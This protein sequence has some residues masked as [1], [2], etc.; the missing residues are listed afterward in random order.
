[1]PVH[2]DET[3]LI[4]SITQRLITLFNALKRYE[5]LLNV[6]KRH[7]TLYNTVNKLKND[8]YFY[9]CIYVKL[10]NQSIIHLYNKYVES[11]DNRDNKLLLN[12]C[13]SI[14]FKK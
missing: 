9:S 8:K 4:L 13:S 6:M 10:N 2:K 5:T 3:L 12:K 1:M 11:I 7:E 14:Y